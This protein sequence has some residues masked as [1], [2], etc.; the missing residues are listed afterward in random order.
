MPVSASLLW[1]VCTLL[2]TGV[3]STVD[4]TVCLGLF[5]SASLFSVLIA[6]WFA[7]ARLY[8]SVLLTLP[9]LSI[10]DFSADAIL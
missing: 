5:A 3:V 8:A 10:L 6:R 7:A 4:S 2:C 9:P 1:M